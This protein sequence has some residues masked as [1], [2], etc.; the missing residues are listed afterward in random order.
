[1]G[2]DLV[3]VF[4]EFA[5]GLGGD[6]LDLLESTGLNESSLGLEVEGE[7]LSELGAD[8]GEDVVGGE[9][10][11]GLEGGDVGAHLDDVLESLL[12][13]ILKVL[14]ALGKHVDGK[15]SGGNISL[16]EELGVLGGVSSDLSKRPG[17]GG[18]EMVLG[19]V[20]ETVLKGRDTLGDDDS[21]GEGIIEGG[22]VS[23]GHDTGKSGVTLGLRDVVDG[24]S[25]TSRVD[26]ELGEL[27][28][29][30][31][32]FSDAGSG[33]L[34]DL[35]I[36][37]LKAVEDSGEDLSL[38][39]NFSE[40]DGVLGDLGEALADVSLELGIGVGDKGSKVGD[41]T[42]VND[43]LSELLGVLGNFGEGSGGN[44]LEGELGLLDAEDEE[45][46]GS[47]INDS[48]G[49]LM[50]VLGDAGESE[51]GSLLN[52]GVELLKAVDES[53]EGT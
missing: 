48:L 30:L 20:D 14:G 16:S 51:G 13:L 37:I 17:S 7:D 44:S 15:E 52:R 29:L 22:D 38:N 33:V 4:S 24:S 12:G 35:N 23:E 26:D 50:V 47:G 40:V 49:K 9:L 1:M 11:E 43:G 19:L 25:G 32:D 28:G 31:S 21:H 2:V 5:A 18:L 8:V 41:G 45:S 3:D 34:T 36:D 53:V 46:N 10:E 39:D 6:F 42:L 27:G